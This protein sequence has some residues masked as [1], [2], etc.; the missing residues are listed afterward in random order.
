MQDI[1]DGYNSLPISHDL[2]I[3]EITSAIGEEIEAFNCRFASIANLVSSVG[4]VIALNKS[5]L[6]NDWS[7]FVSKIKIKIPEESVA[8]IS[9]HPDIVCINP[10]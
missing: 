10:L 1:C 9:K 2:R 6:K 3:Q 4:G 5:E 7:I 8:I